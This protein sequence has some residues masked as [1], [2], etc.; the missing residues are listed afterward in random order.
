[1]V[2]ARWPR[3]SVN[4]DHEHLV[5]VLY[6]WGAGGKFLINSLAVSDSAVLQDVQI[7]QQQIHA[8]LTVQHKKDLVLKR[9]EQEHTQWQ[10]LNFSVDALTGV[11]ERMYIIH[12]SDT[13]QYWPWFD[14]MSVLTQSTHTW[15][16]DIHD[17]GHLA[18]A[19]RVW[20][21][22]KIIS[23]K[24]TDQ[25]LIWRGVNY[26]RQALQQFWNDIRDTTW[27]KQAP[28]TWQ[29]FQNLDHRIQQELLHVRAGD[30]FRFIQHPAAK[31]QHDQSY[32]ASVQRVC[33][34]NEVWRFDTNALL[35]ADRF[36]Q[37]LEH[38]YAWLGF[39]DFDK[40]FATCYH[41]QWLEKIQQVP[42]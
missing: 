25:F 34:R 33:A 11:N 8:E 6:P 16:F 39:R 19:L 35:D 38:C 2:A 18:A 37:E 4:F 42:I 41:A 27:P 21:R 13:A 17:T 15:F 7:A 9:L 32:E 3:P 40:Q 22:A 29:E 14:F 28:L 20:P 24:N 10:D 26:N 31:A 12:G 30:I 36:T 1:M 5:F 23:F